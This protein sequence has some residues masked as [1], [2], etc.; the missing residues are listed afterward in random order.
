MPNLPPPT[1]I[2]VYLRS[3]TP[4]SV[5]YEFHAADSKTLANTPEFTYRKLSPSTAS[6]PI[7]P[8]RI[9]TIKIPAWLSN[10]LEQ[11]AKTNEPREIGTYTSVGWI[12]YSLLEGN[13]A[14]PSQYYP[15]SQASDE[16]SGKN[17]LKGLGY[18]LEHAATRHLKK[19]G[20]K[21]ITV[22]EYAILEPRR[23]QLESVQL[24]TEHPAPIDV[25]I[26]AMAN[27][28]RRRAREYKL[29]AK[30]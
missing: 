18:L 9:A 10:E 25:W 17:P 11:Y 21:N 5:K 3:Q 16:L 2:G 26:E 8:T 29:Q 6:E 4:N 22:H 23:K 24:P 12:D 7:K 1:H 13:V 20:V 28:V 19:L 30:K 27:G 15:K 14:C